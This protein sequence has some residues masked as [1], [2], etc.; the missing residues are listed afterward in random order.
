MKRIILI[1]VV[2]VLAVAGVM[3]YLNLN[4]PAPPAATLVPDSTLVF[5]D[6]PH[7]AQ[8]RADF[9][10]SAVYALWQEPEVQAFL[11]E[12]LHVL[13]EGVNNAS[14]SNDVSRFNDMAFD[15]L[16]GEVFLAVTRISPKLQAGLIFGADVQHKQL[17]A[18]TALTLYE[19]RLAQQ[20]PEF[21]I[22]TVKYLGVKYTVY[23]IEPG[24]RVCDAFLNSMLV[25]TAGEDEMRDVIARFTGQ[26]ETDTPS[27]AASP[28]YQNVL[29][30]LPPGRAF[31]SYL[32]IEQVMSLVGPFLALAP[33]GAAT[34]RKLGRIQATSLSVAF[35]GDKI[36]DVGFTAY[37]TPDAAPPVLQRKTLALTT[38]HTSLYNVGSQ[39]LPSLYQGIMDSIAQ[40]QNTSLIAAAGKFERVMTAHGLHVRDDVLASLGPE[41]A[42]I[43]IWRD[44]AGYPDTA[45][46]TEIQNPAQTRPRLDVALEALREAAWET[47]GPAAWEESSYLGQ[48]LHTLHT[49]PGS[50]SPTYVVTDSFFILAATPV[51][52]RDLL[53]QL[54]DPAP[55]LASNPDYQ[56]AMQALPA[57]AN[58][59]AYCDMN[60]VF[61]PLYIR[62]RSSLAAAGA[63]DFADPGKLPSADAIARHLT[64]FA[65]ATVTGEKDET[66]T[67]I[68]PLGKPLTLL[69]AAAGGIVIA[70]PYLAPYLPSFTPGAPTTSSSTAVPLPPAGNQTAPSQTP[71]TP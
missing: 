24:R 12:P 71:A 17:Q 39:D 16:Q 40:S 29:A 42:V 66:T 49:G 15:A 10:H 67:T 4:K 54:K 34:F 51:C 6:A 35:N 14:G 33:Q 22:D 19:H 11:A 2:L 1:L 52:A 68:S 63:N 37:S 23:E 64:P 27:L 61:R 7:F 69:L 38:A 65:S 44:G 36:Q 46:V 43:A 45:L 41:V 70:E 53:K 25:F 28:K 62:L 57:N 58:S 59:F 60:A 30:H 21:A 55:T 56:Q 31:V 48:T 26:V 3:V 9:Q 18:K 32:N 50:I 13:A 5:L 47:N 20:H 8:S